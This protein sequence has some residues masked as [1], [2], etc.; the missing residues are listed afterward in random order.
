MLLITISTIS[1]YKTLEIFNLS[2]KLLANNDFPIYG[3]P[4]III[5]IGVLFL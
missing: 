5:I 4:N 2:A 3:A 1:V